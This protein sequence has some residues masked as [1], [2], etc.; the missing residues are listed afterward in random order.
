MPLVV[1]K[2]SGVSSMH[3]STAASGMTKLSSATCTISPS[4][5]AS[6]SGSD[7]SMRVPWPGS[8]CTS[9]EPRSESTSRLTTSMPTPRP[10][11]SV[12]CRGGGEAGQ[13]DQLEDLPFGQ[14][15]VGGHEAAF[16]GLAED[17]GG[18]QARRR[19]R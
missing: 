13:E 11:T 14:L 3:S 1:A 8:L 2:R 7:R 17:G 6:V 4:M 9:I 15:G 18:V 10:E 5:M 16:P 19:R 12:T